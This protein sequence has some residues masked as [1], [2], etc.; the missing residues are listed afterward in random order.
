MRDGMNSRILLDA[1]KSCILASS[2]VFRRQQFL[3]RC[4][5]GS[6][7]QRDM[8][9][10]RSLEVDS[11][12]IIRAITPALDPTRHKGQAGNI[13][14]IGGCREYTGAPYFSAISALKIGADLSH[15]FCT[16]D[17]AP[18]IKSYS[19]ELIVHPVLE[20]SYN[21]GEEH[22]SSIASKVL[23]EVDKWLERFD[24][25]VVGPGLGRDPFLL[26]CV[27]EIMRHARQSNIPIVIDGD[28]LF[29]V[30]NNLELVSGYALAVLTPN[31]NEYKRLVQKVLSSEVNDIDAPQQLL[32]L[33]KQIGGVTILRKGN[34]D[35]ISDGDTVKSVSV[36]G[37][38][39]RCGG[40]GDILSGSVAV[41]LS[42]ARQHILA[43]DSNSNIRFKNPTVLGCIA[44]SAILRKAAS[45]AFSNKKRST[46]TGDIIECLGK[47]LED[48]SP[49]S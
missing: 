46:V 35:L 21:V 16:T 1:A 15:V 27:S 33:A 25:L 29:L 4:V 26:D 38:P 45:L 22:K 7:D 37:S 19:P 42:W 43:A 20:E 36:Y 5:G 44:G 3:I 40:Q 48:I 30:T 2:P 34:S 39:R 14:V 49:A 41:F 32:S 12:S 47:S 13:A 17:A 31:V 28:G 6:T 18:V 11:Q 10:L 24:C 23:A 8:Q 9:A